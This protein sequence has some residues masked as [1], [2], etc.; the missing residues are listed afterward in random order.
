MKCRDIIQILEELAPL[1]LAKDWDNVGL[2]VGN[3]EKDVKNIMIALD[4]TKEVIKQGI[5]N[6]ID[7][8]ITHHP[9]IYSPVKKITYDD[10]IG[11]R[12]IDLIGNDIAYY[13][14]HT[15]FDATVM[16]KAAAE[17]LKLANLKI[18]DPDMI[19]SRYGIGCFGNLEERMTLEQCADF[20]K[21][22]F[23]MDHIRIVGNGKKQVSLVAVS[24]GSGKSLIKPALLNEIDVLITGDIDHHTGID[25]YEQGLC[26][27][28]G[29]HFG[30]E[31]IMVEYM[32]QYLSD[33]LAKHYNGK[34][35]IK[36]LTAKEESPFKI[37]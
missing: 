1:K 34:E 32:K 24:P 2:L 9:M 22:K 15:N 10:F 37:L 3:G 21:E 11:R 16:A 20:V 19:D 7:M 36:I 8:L 33:Y 14:M 12:I 30:T 29:G 35:D 6:N 5:E 13:A 17:K 27:I 31:H 25:A 28:D 26:I 23:H 18:L 4:P